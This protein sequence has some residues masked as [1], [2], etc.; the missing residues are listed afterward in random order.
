MMLSF[1]WAAY[2]LVGSS[3]FM[4]E[5]LSGLVV[6]LLTLPKGA[7]ETEVTALIETYPMAYVAET[8]GPQ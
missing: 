5:K 3:S 6:E 7:G 4:F 1:R 2:G 8:S